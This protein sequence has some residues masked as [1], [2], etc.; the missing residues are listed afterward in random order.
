MID[1]QFFDIDVLFEYKSCWSLIP[2]MGYFILL[3]VIYLPGKIRQLVIISV[4]KPFFR[5][6]FNKSKAELYQLFIL[7]SL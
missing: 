3:V 1:G 7:V 6:W 2:T 5:K 4:L